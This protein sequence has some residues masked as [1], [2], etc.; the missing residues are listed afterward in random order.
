MNCYHVTKRILDIIFAV[1]GL[2]LLSPLILIIAI[3]IR[4]QMGSPVLFCQPRTGKNAEIFIIYKFRTMSNPSVNQNS[5][6]ADEVRLTG[7]GKILRRTSLDELPELWH[8]IKGDMSLV[9]PRPL[10]PEYIP[11][12]TPEQNRRHEVKPGITGWAQINGRNDISWE[13]KFRL[14][15]WYVD[16]RSLMLDMKILFQTL[17]KVLHG[18]GVTKSGHVTTDRF[19]GSSS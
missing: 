6:P 4:L 5:G 15:V 18:E 13:N 1:C 7:L 2:I 16:H 11:L 14:D 19:R 10:L 9:G 3:A 17:L 8:V 12:Y